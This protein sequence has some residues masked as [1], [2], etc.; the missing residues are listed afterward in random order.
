M[1]S[2]TSSSRRPARSALGPVGAAIVCSVALTLLAP[3]AASA[4]EEPLPSDPATAAALAATGEQTPAPAP[5]PAPVGAAP[6]SGPTPTPPPGPTADPAPAPAPTETAAPTEPSAP[7]P[8]P[9]P[10]PTETAAP[11]EP[12]APEPAPTPEAPRTAARE[13]T[14]STYLAAEEEPL[15]APLAVGAPEPVP[16]PSLHWLVS[17]AAAGS[18]FELQ[19]RS[20]AGTALGGETWWADWSAWSASATIADCTTGCASPGDLDA[21][22]G[23]LQVSEAG[24]IAVVADTGTERHEYRV[25]P[26]LAPAGRSWTDTSWRTASVTAQAAD[27]GTFTTTSNASLSCAP[28]SFYSLSATGVITRVTPAG[29]GA[30]TSQ[31]F[32]TVPSI[33]SNAEANG[34]GIGPGGTSAFLI[35]RSSATASGISA[36]HHYSVSQG[37]QRTP[38]SNDVSLDAA[39]FTTG[40]V[41]LAD[42]SYYFS[43]F[44][45]GGSQNVSVYRFAPGQGVRAVGTF[46]TLESS[47]QA[48]G[49]LAFDAAGNLYV[50]MTTS[51]GGITRVYT[52][53][54]AALASA[55]GGTLAVAS[56]T[57]ATTGL[58]G[59]VGAAFNADGR[60]YLGSATTVRTYNPATQ[61]FDAGNA[62]TGLSSTDLASCQAPSTLTVVKDVVARAGA[63]DQFTIGARTPGGAL[64]DEATTSGSATGVQPVQAGPVAAL[65]GGTYSFSETFSNANGASYATSFTCIDQDGAT[66]AVDTA[67]A[68][69]GRVTIATAGRSVTCTIRNSPL[70]GS[71]VIR[72]V[73]EDAEGA[74]RTPGVGW[75]VTTGVTATSGTVTPA[76]ATTRTTQTLQTTPASPAGSATWPLAF[77]SPSARAT[78]SVS[79]TQQAGYAFQEGA[80]IVRPIASAPFAQAFTSAAGTT[81]TGVAPGTRIECSFVNRQQPTRLTL[82]NQ[83]D[84][85]DPAVWS[86]SAAPAGGS[87]IAF[88]SGVARDVSA[89]TYALAASGGPATHVGGAWSCVDQAGAAVGVSGASVAVAAGAR[90]TCTILHGTARLVLLKHIDA[91]MA[92]TL[93]PGDFEL[94]ATPSDASLGLAPTT[95][96]GAE[97]AAPTNTFAVR[98]GAA[99][100]LTET[101]AYAYLQLRLQRLDGGTWV[102]VTTTE[103]AAPAVGQTVT[104]RFVNAAPPALALPLTGGIGADAYL[105]G[106]LA[107]LV[108]ATAA[109]AVRIRVVRRDRRAA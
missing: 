81:L 59:I 91:S 25:R 28:G 66:V 29:G 94:T 84:G 79:E 107:L 62:A 26:V 51:G 23:E 10:A 8:A 30:S 100:A 77:G 99:Y 16:A 105:L 83:A 78:V 65:V 60:L 75:S 96:T 9:A 92:G 56:V 54:A 44:G 13:T 6:V 104:Y 98:P 87:P 3:S 86:L 14:A 103:I 41:S 52:I 31:A 48:T 4:S 27:L 42:G 40:A 12:S 68:G 36:F 69:T 49:D 46:A 63:T 37:W 109:L 95:V 89:A 50:A 58:N 33:G 11:T 5:E 20:R 43:A 71:V 32:G 17:P 101:S 22:T 2:R 80:C 35:E 1:R 61:S 85:A 64:L 97:A 7:A 45:N 108:L 102:D 90:V 53:A 74:V 39:R 18:T 73:V 88:T 82:V 24:T 15:A 70:T 93:E 19:H 55:S 67:T 47:Q 38:V 21:D 72:K 76:G 34:L 57:P 106:G